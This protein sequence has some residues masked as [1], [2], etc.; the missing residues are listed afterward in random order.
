MEN[1]MLISSSMR[2]NP[3]QTNIQRASVPQETN[4]APS[5]CFTFSDGKTPTLVKAG[6]YALAAATTAGAGALAYFASNNIGTAATVAGVASGALA[7]ATILGTVGL[8]AD[9]GGGIF[10]N[11]NKALPAA[12]VGGVLGGGAGGALGAFAQSPATGIAM[13]VVSGLSA[14][15]LTSSATNILAD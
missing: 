14:L 2:P 9:I 7:G 12:V 10:G 15:A 6:K 1:T 13:G 3:T 4:N 8:M 5:E 11:S